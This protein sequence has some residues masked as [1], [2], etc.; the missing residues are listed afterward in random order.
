MDARW[1]LTTPR[2]EARGG[3]S[4]NPDELALA[5]EP[6]VAGTAPQDYQK[7]PRFFSR[8]ARVRARFPV[9]RREENWTLP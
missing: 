8:A 6:V 2:K 9:F 3:R 5:L 7:R 1:K 4:F